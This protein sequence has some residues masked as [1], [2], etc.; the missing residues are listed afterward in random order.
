MSLIRVLLCNHDS[1]EVAMHHQVSRNKQNINQLYFILMRL[2]CYEF[3][4]LLI[5]YFFF[6]L[7]SG[8]LC[9][10]VENCAQKRFRTR[11]K[12]AQA[13]NSLKTKI[14]KTNLFY[15]DPEV[16]LSKFLGGCRHEQTM[17]GGHILRGGERED[18]VHFP[19]FLVH[20]KPL[21]TNKEEPRDEI[22]YKE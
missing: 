11:L 18:P 3:S 6:N 10:K 22:L 9:P 15:R 2:N 16:I 5:F 19:V 21:V 4:F 17:E 14:G 1:T 12:T 8:K 20:S 13:C 7:N